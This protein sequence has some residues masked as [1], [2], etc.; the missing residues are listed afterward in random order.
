MSQKRIVIAGGSGFIGASLAREFTALKY[1]VAVLT[2]SPRPRR[3]GVQEVS[4]DAKSAGDWI[5][6]LD[7]AN[8][9]INLTGKSINCPHTPQ[10]VRDI[11]AS[12][13][14]S[15]NA[16]ASA[17]AQVKS[18]PA[19]W[20]QA[21][22]TGF[23]G[24][25][26][27]ALCDESSPAGSHVLSGICRQWEESFAA[28]SAPQTRKVV[29]RIGF[30]LGRE[31]GAL[32]VLSRLTRCFLGGAAGSGRQYVSWIHLADLTRMFVLAVERESLTGTYNAVAPHAATNAELMRELRRVWHRPWCPPAPAFAVRL[33]SRLMGAEPSLA[34]ISSRCAPKKF[35]AQEFPFQFPELRPA[36]ENLCGVVPHHS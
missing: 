21:S 9:I 8:A 11:T 3:D 1:Q 17:L 13:V 23:Y 10:A 20:V 7:G 16:I 27:S 5:R 26:G 4:W 36:L 33:G 35:M 34:L 12:R 6:F 2:R 28:A 29:L 22:A 24:D 14:D 30:V 18:A 32:P 25:T 19:V 15:V 31:G